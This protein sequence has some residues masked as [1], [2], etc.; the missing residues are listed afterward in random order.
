MLSTDYFLVL[1]VRLPLVLLL[2]SEVVDD[3]WAALKIPDKSHGVKCY[4]NFNTNLLDLN[5]W[6][7]GVFSTTSSLESVASKKGF[8]DIHHHY[9]TK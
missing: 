5:V 9:F 6:T 8:D 4:G 7:G 2:L 1:L 3:V